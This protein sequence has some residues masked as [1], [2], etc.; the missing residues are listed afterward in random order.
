MKLLISQAT[1]GNSRLHV[2]QVSSDELTDLSC[3]DPPR[4]S[5]PW[6]GLGVWFPLT[7]FIELLMLLPGVEVCAVL[8][9]LSL[10]LT[11]LTV[12]IDE[13]PGVCVSLVAGGN[14]LWDCFFL[15]KKKDIL[16]V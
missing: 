1:Y 11:P 2:F 4:W 10:L 15:P 13:P 3:S 8:G 7:E 6:S 9:P 16:A 5:I 14:G 12:G